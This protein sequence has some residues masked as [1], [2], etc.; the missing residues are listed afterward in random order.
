MIIHKNVTFLFAEI[1]F[2]YKLWAINNPTFI[3]L[4]DKNES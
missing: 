4:V 1:P 2:I 3:K